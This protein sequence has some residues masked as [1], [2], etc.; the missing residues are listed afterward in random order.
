MQSFLFLGATLLLLI[1][2][3]VVLGIYIAREERA[4]KARGEGSWRD[5]PPK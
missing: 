2:G 5:K 3:A 4:R 1:L